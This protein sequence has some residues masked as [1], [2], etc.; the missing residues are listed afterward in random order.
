MPAKLHHIS[1]SVG[2]NLK[3][4]RRTASTISAVSPSIEVPG[5]KPETLA[6]FHLRELE[7][8]MQVGVCQPSTR[9]YY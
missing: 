7:T 5:I 2:L 1:F 9:S 3:V 4:S 8:T 6:H